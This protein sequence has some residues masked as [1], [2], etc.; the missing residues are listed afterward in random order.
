[1]ERRLEGSL[2]EKV[3]LEWRPEEV[4][5]QVTWVFGGSVVHSRGSDNQK[6]LRLDPSGAFKAAGVAGT[7]GERGR[8]GGQWGRGKP[9]REGQAR[10]LVSAPGEMG[11]IGEFWVDDLTPSLKDHSGCHREPEGPRAK[12]GDPPEG[13]RC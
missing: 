11:A 9:D 5:E 13:S 3:T 1:M 2:S 7:A 10:T 12:Q 8:L 6:A 4:R